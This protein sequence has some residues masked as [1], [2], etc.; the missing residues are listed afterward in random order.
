MQKRPWGRQFTNT[1]ASN[2]STDKII[3]KRA[4]LETDWILLDRVEGSHQLREKKQFDNFNAT[5]VP[6]ENYTQQLG[7]SDL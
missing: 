3:A 4:E 5:L 1:A 7:G 6:P 2:F